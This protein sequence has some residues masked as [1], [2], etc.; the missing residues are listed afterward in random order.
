MSAAV[1]INGILLGLVYTTMALGLSITLGVMRIINVAHSAFIILGTYAGFQIWRTWDVNP[2][3]ALV[4]LAPVFFVLGALVARYLVE[5]LSRSDETMVLVSL[6]GLL[7]VLETVI[8]LVWTADSRSI[9]LSYSS[10]VLDLGFARVSYARLITGAAC[11][12]IVL[13]VHLF[14]QYSATGKAI[15]AMSENRDAATVL[16]VNVRLL[17]MVVFGLTTAI[18]AFSGAALSTIFAFTPQVH[19]SWLAWAFLIVVL[20]GLG[21]IGATLVSG[22]LVGMAESI[23]G[24]LMPF[25]YVYL[26]M[27]LL[28]GLV[29]LFRSEGLL[30]RAQV[31]RI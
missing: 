15:R 22:L 5:P 9:N 26:S 18:A 4:V 12:A 24:Q 17:G 7:V 8:T 25:Q 10:S 28:L 23:L 29:M 19:Y 16:G 30:A 27:F 2:L 31:R 13:L 6:F 20:G 3:V 11:L 21:S 1:L 14:M